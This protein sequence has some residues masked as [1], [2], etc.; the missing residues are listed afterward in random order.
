MFRINTEVIQRPNL[1]RERPPNQYDSPRTTLA[2]KGL[3]TSSLFTP[4][5]II[6]RKRKRIVIKTNLCCAIVFQIKSLH[7]ILR[8][9]VRR[10]F[11]IHQ[12]MARSSQP[13]NSPHLHNVSHEDYW[14]LKVNLGN[15]NRGRQDYRNRFLRAITV[16][17]YTID[18]TKVQR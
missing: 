16:A 10:S 3:S 17:F 9:Y 7:C 13:I 14:A 1:L 2:I 5:T 15:E 12:D 8:S 11:Q 18:N 6:Y 4:F